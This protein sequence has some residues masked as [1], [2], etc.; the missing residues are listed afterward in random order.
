MYIKYN[1]MFKRNYYCKGHRYL[2]GYAYYQRYESI[3]QEIMQY[4]LSIWYYGTLMHVGDRHQRD[5][6]ND[7][8]RLKSADCRLQRT[9]GIST[10][11]HLRIGN[12]NNCYY[13]SG[14][15]YCSNDNNLSTKLTK[16]PR[17]KCLCSSML[18]W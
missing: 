9:L 5:L 12:R 15:R 1:I 7:V 16:P 10:Y 13:S 8:G 14:Y 4:P 17:S 3:T 6:W 2:R 11:W 18:K